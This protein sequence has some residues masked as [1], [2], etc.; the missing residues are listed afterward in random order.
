MIYL[1]P[2]LLGIFTG[3]KWIKEEVENQLKYKGKEL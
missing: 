1:C 3:Q 2:V